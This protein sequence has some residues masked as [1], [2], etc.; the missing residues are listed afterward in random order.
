MY[1]V[2]KFILMIYCLV[3]VCCL[4]CIPSRLAANG[5]VGLRLADLIPLLSHVPTPFLFRCQLV[6]VVSALAFHRCRCKFR[7]RRV[8]VP[9]TLSL[10]YSSQRR[11]TG[12]VRAVSVEK[13]Y[14][15][16]VQLVGGLF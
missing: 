10:A 13:I 11:P 7:L 4:V 8:D 1:S 14:D 9:L 16:F 12:R 3:V 2:A 5:T 15:Y 6:R